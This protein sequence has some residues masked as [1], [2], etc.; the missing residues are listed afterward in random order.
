M[1][2]NITRVQWRLKGDM[3][4]GVKF[5]ETTG[6]FSGT[7]LDAGEYTIPVHV[8]T[9]YGNDEKDVKFVVKRNVLYKFCI[10][11]INDLS[12]GAVTIVDMHDYVNAFG[13]TESVCLQDEGITEVEYEFSIGEDFNPLPEKKV[14]RPGTGTIGSLFTCDYD[15]ETGRI[16][17]TGLGNKTSINS[18]HLLNITITTN[19]SYTRWRFKVLTNSSG[20]NLISDS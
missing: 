11:R 6:T 7:P 8:K 3:P 14:P 19:T 16:T 17:F 5:D 4:F 20:T 1:P 10:A 18:S 2:P 15:I 12:A 13:V 9:N